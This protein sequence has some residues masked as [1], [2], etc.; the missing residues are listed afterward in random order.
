M[1]QVHMWVY[2]LIGLLVLIAVSPSGN[3][4]RGGSDH[5]DN[6]W[7]EGVNADFNDAED[8]RAHDWSKDH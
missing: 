5:Y 6:S 3:G 7:E 1:D 8:R 4:H 2:G